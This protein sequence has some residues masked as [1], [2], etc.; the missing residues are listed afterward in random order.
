MASRF[1][2][3]TPNPPQV[4]QLSVRAGPGDADVRAWIWNHPGSAAR[5]VRDMIRREIQSGERAGQVAAPAAAVHA[6]Q[7]P[8][9]TL[10]P[11]PAATPVSSTTQAGQGSSAPVAPVAHQPPGGLKPAGAGGSDRYRNLMA[12]VTGSPPA[13]E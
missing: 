10:A 2:R 6:Q 4:V 13:T 3:S 11:V 1:Q 12:Q 9:V 8:A 7:P 5:M